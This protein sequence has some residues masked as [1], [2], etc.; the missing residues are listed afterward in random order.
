MMMKNIFGLVILIILGFG[1]S[2]KPNFPLEPSITFGK[3]TNTA[4]EDKNSSTPS[5]KVFKDSLSIT[6]NFRDGNGDLGVNEADKNKLSEKGEFNYI[7]RRFIRVKGK[8][9][10]FNPVPSHSGNFVT[11]KQGAKAGPIEGFINYAI[12][13]LPLNGTK[14]DT[15]KFEIQILDRAKNAS[16]AV[17][18]DSVLVNELNKKTLVIN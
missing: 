5:K 15:V 3:I 8:Y 6:I 2:Q 12:E 18:T 14:K 9:Y 7:V 17:M 16:N 4:V 11:L 10:E 13:F 1:C